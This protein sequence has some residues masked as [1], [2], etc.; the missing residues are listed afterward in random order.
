MQS[1]IYFTQISNLSEARFAAS[2]MAKGIGF[3]LEKSQPDYVTPAILSSFKEWLVGPDWIADLSEEPNDAIKEL[4]EYFDIQ[5]IL[6]QH[7]LYQFQKDSICLTA[8][9]IVAELIP[10]MK[11]ED[12]K[13]A[14]E[15]NP[16]AILLF[17]NKEPEVGMANMDH[18]INYFEAIEIL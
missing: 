7:Q 3:C 5:L 1:D 6:H 18:W 8:A 9:N 17:G 2:V 14:I 13:N 12:Y 11:P 10:L 15:T 4:M 16:K